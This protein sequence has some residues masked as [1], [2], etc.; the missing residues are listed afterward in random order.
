MSS[1]CLSCLW[2]PYTDCGFSILWDVDLY[3]L[4]VLF[5]QFCWCPWALEEC[6]SMDGAYIAALLNFPWWMELPLLDSWHYSHHTEGKQNQTSFLL[7]V[8]LRVRISYTPLM[9]WSTCYGEHANVL[10]L[11]KCVDLLAS[12]AW[13]FA[14]NFVHWCGVPSSVTCFPIEWVAPWSIL[15]SIFACFCK[16]Y[17]LPSCVSVFT[18]D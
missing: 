2:V 11:H 15:M 14:Q 5:I 16:R 1:V 13:N 3:I 17:L 6:A 9:W 10:F 7:N 8:L 4:W 12:P 18:R